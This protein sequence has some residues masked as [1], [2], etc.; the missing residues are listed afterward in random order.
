LW[1]IVMSF[2]RTTIA[3]ILQSLIPGEFKRILGICAAF[4]FALAVFGQGINAPFAGMQEPLQAQWI[5]D[6]VSHRHWLVAFDYYGMINLKPPLYCWLSALIAECAGGHVTETIARVVSLLAGT[7]LATEVLFWAMANVGRTAGLSAYGV[8]LGSYGF[9][10]FATV[11]ITDML[12]SFLLFSAYCISYPAMITRAPP[13][14]A[15]LAGIILGLA[16]LTKGPV[17]VVLYAFAIVLFMILTGQ[18]PIEPGRTGWLW[19]VFLTTFLIAGPWYALAAGEYGEQFI[20]VVF[21]ENLGHAFSAAGTYG[22]GP[23]H[24][25]SFIPIRLIRAALP[26]V[27]LLIPLAFIAIFGLIPQSVRKP[28]LFHFS[29]VIVVTLFFS[30]AHSVQ[31]YY[32]LPALPGLAI[33]ISG[34]F[35]MQ[36]EPQDRKHMAVATGVEATLAAIAATMLA[37]VLGSWWYCAHGSNLA[38]IRFRLCSDDWVLAQLYSRGMV[39]PH[40]RF[41]LLL[42][43]TAFGA[44][45]TFGGL[46]LRRRDWAGAGVVVLAIAGTTFW[47]GTMRNQL[48]QTLSIKQFAAAVKAQTDNAP[49]YTTVQNYELA[50]YYGRGL[51]LLRHQPFHDIFGRGELRPDLAPLKRALDLGSPAY[52][53]LRRYEQCYLRRGERE[54]LHAVTYAAPGVFGNPGL[55]LIASVDRAGAG[56]KGTPGADCRRGSRDGAVGAGL[57]NETTIYRAGPAVCSLLRFGPYSD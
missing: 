52:V 10:S 11:A 48:Y 25:I 51:P 31:S 56:R 1:A 22:T 33:L 43:V 50:F 30:F 55:F 53:V 6:T 42:L 28:L 14:R 20:S 8:L 23:P 21:T 18:N 41:L 40:G 5:Q 12:M 47:I 36:V 17:A 44:S 37:L 13:A 54:S 45:L 7:A 34:V 2:K 46:M 57:G 39:P 38:V 26:S 4:G 49:V 35:A 32:V 27:F 3:S 24:G 29:L 15:I 19:R 9:A 16:V